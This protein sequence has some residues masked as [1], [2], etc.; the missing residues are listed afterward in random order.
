MRDKKGAS[1]KKGECIG[2]ATNVYSRKMLEKPKKGVCKF[3]KIRVRELLM[4]GEGI[5]TPRIHHNGRQ[6]LIECEKS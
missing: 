5:I 4:R 3:S 1:S 2:V 6:P